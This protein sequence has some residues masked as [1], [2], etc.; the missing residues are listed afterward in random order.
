MGRTS[1]I[2]RPLLQCETAKNASVTPGGSGLGSRLWDPVWDLGLYR[3]HQDS[4]R[5]ATNFV[6]CDCRYLASW[7]NLTP[8]SAHIDS[9]R[10]LTHIFTFVR[11]H[12]PIYY[13]LSTN[14]TNTIKYRKCKSTPSFLDTALAGKCVLCST[15]V[16]ASVPEHTP[17]TTNTL[18]ISH[19]L[20]AIYV[21]T[22]CMQT[23]GKSSHKANENY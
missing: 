14:T 10:P 18:T 4:P 9:H 11:Q 3:I 20:Y 5:G 17:Y 7:S 21:C 19:T 2:Y 13:I 6:T 8:T 22:R 23:S 15:H 16:L 1:S 12:N